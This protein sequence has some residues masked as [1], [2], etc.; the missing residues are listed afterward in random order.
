MVIFEKIKSCAGKPFY[1]DCN[2]LYSGPRK[3]TK[4]HLQVARDHGYTEVII[5]EE[6]DSVV[7]E[8]NLKHCKRVYLGAA[9]LKAPVII[10]LTHFKIS[11]YF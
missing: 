8:V 7:K 10:A 9:G 4:T 3:E 2:T 11:K 5:P 6:D 1:T